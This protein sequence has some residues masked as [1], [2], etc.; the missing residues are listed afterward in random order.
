MDWRKFNSSLQCMGISTPAGAFEVALFYI[1]ASLFSKKRIENTAKQ[2][3]PGSCVLFISIGLSQAP[4]EP[5]SM[6]AGPG[7]NQRSRFGALIG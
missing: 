5:T 4:V 1:N 7:V 2:N 6:R 3:V